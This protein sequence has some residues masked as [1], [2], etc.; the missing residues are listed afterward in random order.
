MDL[1]TFKWCLHLE[2]EEEEEWGDEE[3]ER[4]RRKEMRRER[5]RRRS[6]LRSD[7]PPS[8][9]GGVG[10]RGGVGR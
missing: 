9:S 2:E 4:R 6:G 8:L 7:T 3:E 5:R 10:V 1:F